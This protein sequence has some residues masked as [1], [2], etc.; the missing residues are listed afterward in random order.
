M[1]CSA[2]ENSQYW[3]EVV[4]AKELIAS[5]AIGTPLSGRA[6]HHGVHDR[7]ADWAGRGTGGES[8]EAW[9]FDKEV[10]GGGVVIDGGACALHSPTYPTTPTAKE[11]LS[12]TTSVCSSA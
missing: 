1:R 8:A 4:T 11:N 6:W 2:Q 12:V 9:R 5:G 3:P 10:M 7:S